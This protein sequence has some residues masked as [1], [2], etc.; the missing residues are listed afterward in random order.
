ML[1]LIIINSLQDSK[2]PKDFK[3]LRD[4]RSLE[5]PK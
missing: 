3:D 5:Q 4:F 1:A 2:V